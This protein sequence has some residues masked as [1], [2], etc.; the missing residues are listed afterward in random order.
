MGSADW[1]LGSTAGRVALDGR[2]AGWRHPRPVTE[3]TFRQLALEDPEGHW[4]L[5]C[6][7]LRSKDDSVMIAEHG[8]LMFELAVMLRNQLAPPRS[9]FA[10]I[11]GLCVARLESSTSR[12]CWSFPSGSS[13][14]RVRPPRAEA[15][16]GPLPLVV[17]VWSRSTGGVDVSD[18]LPEYRRRGDLEIWLLHPCERRLTTWVRQIDGTYAETVHT[19]GIVWPAHLPDIAIDLAASFATQD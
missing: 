15:Y 17:E 7:R 18:R 2:A 13:A 9:A 5:H 6:G 12:M 14:Q 8:D 11:M 4:E 1:S 10:S 16:S 3:Q 19:G